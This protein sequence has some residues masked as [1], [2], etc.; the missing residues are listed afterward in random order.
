QKLKIANLEKGCFAF[1]TQAAQAIQRLNL[2]NWQQGDSS[3]IGPFFGRRNFVYDM[4]E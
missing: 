1:N 4:S 2:V 3:D